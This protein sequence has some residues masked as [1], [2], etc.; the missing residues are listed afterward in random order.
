M[1]RI[2][3]GLVLFCCFMGF[4]GAAQVRVA[5]D[6]TE[7]PRRILHAHMTF[8]VS[9]GP[10]TLV[11]PKWIP[12][13]HG[14][15]G[16][17][18]GTAGLHFRLGGKELAW[19]RDPVNMYAIHLEVPQG[20]TQLEAD[21]DTLG[22]T[23][24]TGFLLGNSVTPMQLILEWN[25]VVLYRE[26]VDPNAVEYQAS[27]KLPAGW[28]FGTALPV[29]SESG[30]TARFKPVSLYT[31]VDSPLLAGAK[32]RHLDI[33]PEGE[34]RKHYLELAGDTD[35][36]LDIPESTIDSY[37]R[38]VSESGALYGAR[39]YHEYHFLVAMHGTYS[40]GLEHHQSSDNRMAGLGLADPRWRR[41]F[42]TL[43][44]HE[45]THSWN[46]KYRRPAGLA[47]PDFGKPMEGDLLW[48]YEGLTNYLGQ[49][50]AARSGLWTPE[51]FRDEFATIADELSHRPGR[52][53]RSLEDTAVAAQVLYGSSHEWEN[54]RRTV[55]Y[56]DEGSLIW[57]EVDTLLRSSSGGTKS[58]DDFCQAFYGGQ[59]GPPEVVPY[60]FDDVVS[61]LNKIVPYDWRGFFEQRIYR[62]APQ[63]PLGGIEASGWKLTYTSEPGEHAQDVETKEENYNFFPSIG[64]S[65]KQDGEIRD[66]LAGSAAAGAGIAPGSK[67]IA[68]DSY[69]FSTDLLR[70][71]IR[72]A[73]STKAPIELLTMNKDVYETFKVDYHEGEKYPHLERV[74]GGTDMMSQ[75]IAPRVRTVRRSR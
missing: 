23:T 38:L 53:W 57:L 54:W 16:P 8:T 63:A 60:T 28:R 42:A 48:V 58:M 40:N 46:G 17:V 35:A 66:V 45:M 10:L 26:G 25:Q 24:D 75:I 52:T 3:W 39:H 44:T 70:T 15:T 64:L 32:F 50:L 62:V 21:L 19:R 13:E 36:A 68:V 27:I 6:A 49:V 5:V 31:L 11:Y 73:L 65:L 55:D 59:S 37:R 51:Y 34:T 12:G 9:P 72:A 67:L 71:A 4:P 43:L 7:A 69:K 47:S 20:A 1:R 56:Y 14:P 74:S 33:T 18:D 30:G 29:A 2:G 61:T 41:I 22:V